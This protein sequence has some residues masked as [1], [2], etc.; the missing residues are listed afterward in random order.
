L[1]LPL[2]PE[3][4]VSHGAWLDA[5]QAQPAPALTVTFPVDAADGAFADSGVIE[6]VHPGD[7]VM[8]TR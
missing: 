1:P 4:S 7:C 6:N 8:V 3:A 5:V 2:V